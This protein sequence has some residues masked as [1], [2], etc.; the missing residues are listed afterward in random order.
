MGRV[1]VV[2]SSLLFALA[3]LSAQARKPLVGAV[4]DAAGNPVAGAVV[5]LTV[6]G[7]DGAPPL[8]ALDAT[9]DERGRFR[10]QALPCTR[11]EAWAA[12]PADADGVQMVSEVAAL[13]VGQPASLAVRWKGGVGSIEV[14]GLDAWQARAPFSVRTTVAGRT[15]DAPVAAK[16][17][18]H[19][20]SIGTRPRDGADA[21][22]FDRDGRFVFGNR[23]AARAN[24][25][26]RVPPP[27]EI[28]LKVVDEKG[29]PIAGA[30]IVQLPRGDG[31]WVGPMTKALQLKSSPEP[32]AGPLELGV[33]GADGVLKAL[34][35]S[36][37]TPLKGDRSFG[38]DLRLCALAP[39]RA[40]SYGGADYAG[41][42]DD[43]KAV[44]GEECK[45]LTFTLRQASPLR[46]R[47]VDGPRP[48]AGVAVTL[49]SAVDIESG[50]GWSREWADSRRAQTDADGRVAL[51]SPP[52]FGERTTLRLELEGALGSSDGQLPFPAR[53]VLLAPIL[54]DPVAKDAE[55]VIDLATFATVSFAVRDESGG[56]GRGAQVLVVP[57]SDDVSVDDAA[58][59]APDAA[60]R[61]AVRVA[62]G[63]WI[64]VACTQDGFVMTSFYA[65]HAAEVALPVAPFPRM[66]AR[67]VDGDG[68]PVSGA[69]FIVQKTSFTPARVDAE[70]EQAMQEIRW[71]LAQHWNNTLLM[72]AKSDDA[73]V[74]LAPFLPSD[75]VQLRGRFTAGKRSSDEHEAAADDLG[76]VV[77]R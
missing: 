33:T 30:R 51:P 28:P 29:Q 43:G 10:V 32:T 37:G 53:P 65:G 1:V 27:F 69:R 70:V 76:D 52:P 17:G 61:L 38:D 13:V 55:V 26:L 44:D 20:A 73:G 4:V 57:V 47:V 21:A 41:V 6:P 24:E 66:R 42:Y 67:I 40:P 62:P 23:I 63:D 77:V 75:R 11:Y 72:R 48:L 22:L 74:L 50:Q 39:D 3:P 45:A 64:A 36:R 16:A 60:G 71:D 31:M 19:A 25:R 56:P 58:V 49:R 5:Q 34:F 9:T 14:A 2:A 68:K 35:A 59:M 8:D 18:G 7:R 46:V 15:A 54:R 12:G